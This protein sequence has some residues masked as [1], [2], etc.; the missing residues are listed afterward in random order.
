MHSRVELGHRIYN[1][2]EHIFLD[3]ANATDNTLL[4]V[5]VLMDLG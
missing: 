5:V 3:V 1:R 4:P 2:N